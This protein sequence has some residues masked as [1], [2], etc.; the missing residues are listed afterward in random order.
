MALLEIQN[1]TKYF[2]G[3]AAVSELYLDVH[4]GEILGLIGPNG[5]GKTTVFNMIA[6]SSPPTKGNVKFKAEDISGLPPHRIAKKGI[7]RTFQLCTLF[8]DM[9]VLQ[10]VLLGFHLRAGAGFWRALIDKGFRPDHTEGDL[11]EEA[12][13]ILEFMDL[14]D[15]KDEFAKNLP[16]G[17]RKHLTVAIALAANPG[18]SLF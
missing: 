14:E 8:E 9:T 17:H 13:A 10:N 6:G 1:L 5:A 15:S 2:G 3:L 11:S 12:M 16:H 18:F 4:K 7:A